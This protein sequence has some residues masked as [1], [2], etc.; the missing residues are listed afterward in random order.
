MGDMLTHPHLRVAEAD[1]LYLRCHRTSLTGLLVPRLLSAALRRV[2]CLSVSRCAPPPRCAMCAVLFVFIVVNSR[3][4]VSR[5]MTVF[6]FSR[7]S[8][9]ALYLFRKFV[10]R[11]GRDFAPGPVQDSVGAS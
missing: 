8:I 2:A 1:A 7:F 11:R 10:F 9:Y 5:R 6:H 3:L 4:T